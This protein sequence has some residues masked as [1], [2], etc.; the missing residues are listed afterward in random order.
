MTGLGKVQ[1]L[2]QAH[3]HTFS[4]GKAYLRFHIMQCHMYIKINFSSHNMMI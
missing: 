4:H 1:G 2:F 3:H